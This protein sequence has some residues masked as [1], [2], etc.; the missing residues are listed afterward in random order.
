ML[1]ELRAFSR[2][3]LFLRQTAFVDSSIQLSEHLSSESEEDM[4]GARRSATKKQAFVQLE[5]ACI[6]RDVTYNGTGDVMTVVDKRR[7]EEQH[8]KLL[9]VVQ[10]PF[11]AMSLN[12]CLKCQENLSCQTEIMSN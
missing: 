6:A 7:H 10:G 2:L 11:K 8:A 9:L 5:T 1:A 4:K 3:A 12:S